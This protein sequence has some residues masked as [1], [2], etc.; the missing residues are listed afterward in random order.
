MAVFSTAQRSVIDDACTK[1]AP[2][3]TAVSNARNLL[4]RLL[5]MDQHNLLNGNV[6]DD[7]VYASGVAEWVE[8]KGRMQS[9]FAGLP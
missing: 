7:A 2:L 6:N 9:A 3:E 5:D 1:L 8:L 4:A